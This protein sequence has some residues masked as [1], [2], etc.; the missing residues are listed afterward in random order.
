MAKDPAA[1]FY[2][3][4]WLTATKEMKP[5]CRGWYLNLI[6]HQYDKGSLPNDIEELANLADVRFSEFAQFKQVFEQVLR[7][8]FEVNDEGRLENGIAKEI[9]KN[10][11]MF[12]D[13]RSDAGRM[14][15]FLKFAARKKRLETD[16]YLFIKANLDLTG[17]DLK[18]EQVI[19][20]VFKQISELYINTNKDLN[21]DKPLNTAQGGA[22]GILGEMQKL[23]LS[24]N[25]DY[26]FTPDDLSSIREVGCWL[27]DNKD[28]MQCDHTKILTDWETML[29]NIEGNDHWKTYTLQQVFKFRAAIFSYKPKV[30]QMNAIIPKNKFEGRGGIQKYE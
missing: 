24:K 11:E 8:K 25:T 28:I 9:L 27:G 7:Q 13:K 2:I 22:G 1:L 4:T 5:D 18:N 10:R 29:K 19:E 21:K 20:Q 26:K 3:S 14:S 6:L 17:V 15:Y 23:F 12:K 30:L 16:F